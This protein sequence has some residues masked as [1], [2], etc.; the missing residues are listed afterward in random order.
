MS[1]KCGAERGGNGIQEIV[2]PGVRFFSDP[3]EAGT[4]PFFFRGVLGSSTVLALLAFC[5]W[6]FRVISGEIGGVGGT[7]YGDLAGA[8]FALAGFSADFALGGPSSSMIA[9]GDGVSESS[10]NIELFGGCTVDCFGA[11]LPFSSLVKAGASSGPAQTGDL[12]L[13]KGFGK[14]TGVSFF[15]ANLPFESR[16]R[17]LGGLSEHPMEARLFAGVIVEAPGFGANF[18]YLSLSRDRGALST[19]ED[20]VE[21]RLLA[22]VLPG[23][24]SFG[25]NLPCASL[26]NVSVLG[27]EDVDVLPLFG[28]MELDAEEEFFRANLPWE[29][30]CNELVFF[31]DVEVELVEPRLF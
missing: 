11:N 2:F 25:A 8:F 31:S 6:L 19:A 29:S 13:A 22:A 23:V 10:P 30:R 20:P 7:K 15:G 17:E 18:P 14:G 27:F 16:L 3:G 4:F 12:R 26:F 9:S 24:P 5:P 28:L 1:P 21:A